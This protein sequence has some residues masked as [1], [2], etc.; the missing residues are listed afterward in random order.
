MK[1]Y[2]NNINNVYELYKNVDSSKSTVKKQ[3]NFDKVDI[4]NKA[5]T[6]KKSAD[7]YEKEREAK[8]QK[9]K[10]MIEKGTYNVK[11]EDVANAIIKGI[12]IDKKI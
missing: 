4:T 3:Q 9:I 12:L 5:D 6:I 1:I 2:N 7:Q 11:S 8:M 10:S